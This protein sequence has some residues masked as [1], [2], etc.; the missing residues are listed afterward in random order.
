MGFS[1]SVYYTPRRREPIQNQLIYRIKRTNDGRAIRFL[2]DAV[3]QSAE[4]MLRE[5]AVDRDALLLTY[6]P[7]GR[8]AKLFSGIDQAELLARELGRIADLPV[9]TLLLRQ[10]G[11][12]REQKRLSHTARLQNAKQSFLPNTEES[13]RGKV[14]L[15]VD[16]LVTTGAGMSVCAKLL[17]HMGAKAVFCAAVA[18]DSCLKDQPQP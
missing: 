2:A 5:A 6:L 9:K 14:V 16:D 11:A 7:R 3:W 15:L 12:D 1:K 8:R 18:A 17:R 10:R 13:C 4:R